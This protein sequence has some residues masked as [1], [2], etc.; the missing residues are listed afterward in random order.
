[1]KGPIVAIGRFWPPF[2]FVFCLSFLFQLLGRGG[3]IWAV[4][5]ILGCRC[6][7]FLPLEPAGEELRRFK[8]PFTPS[9]VPSADSGG[10][11]LF[12]GRNFEEMLQRLGSNESMLN[13]IFNSM[14]EGVLL[15]TRP[16]GLF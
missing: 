13:V 8:Y 1:M 4:V 6:S 12:P 10:M 9:D 2:T 16:T 3:V 7:A 15:L 11:F 14:G 5:F